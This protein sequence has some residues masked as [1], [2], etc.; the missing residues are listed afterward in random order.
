[1]T[2]SYNI[3]FKVSPSR[4]HDAH[5]SD[6]ATFFTRNFFIISHPI[7]K[8]IIKLREVLS[9]NNKKETF[10]LSLPNTF[11]SRT[12]H[13]LIRLIHYFQ[14]YFFPLLGGKLSFVVSR[15]TKQR[16]FQETIADGNWSFVLLSRQFHDYHSSRIKM[17]LCNPISLRIKSNLLEVSLPSYTIPYT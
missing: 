12:C 17:R 8:F 6:P 3:R 16:F 13:D 2:D 15:L 9:N 7:F 4:P 14:A 11:R 10:S 1:M 5:S